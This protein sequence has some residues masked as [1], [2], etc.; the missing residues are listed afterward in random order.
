MREKDKRVDNDARFS[1]QL[2]ELFS[3]SA[4]PPGVL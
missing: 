2:Q 1:A 3:S 4:P